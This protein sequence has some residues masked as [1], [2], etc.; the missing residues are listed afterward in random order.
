MEGHRYGGRKKGT[1][2]KPKPSQQIIQGILT[3]TVGEYFES[4]EFEKDLAQL[5]P[6][7][8]LMVME[9]LTQYIVPKQQA[10]KVEMNATAKVSQSFAAQIRDLAAQYESPA[11][12]ITTSKKA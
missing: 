3:Q 6:K 4:E 11:M 1:P 8:R 10:Q 5:E 7:D 2:N 12:E 9:R